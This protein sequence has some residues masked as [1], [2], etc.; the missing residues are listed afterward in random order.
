[1]AAPP[2]GALRW[3]PPQAVEHW[4]EP[5]AATNVANT[6]GQVTELGFFGG[7]TEHQ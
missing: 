5:L 3:M 6:C 4:H 7:S 2:V 1:M